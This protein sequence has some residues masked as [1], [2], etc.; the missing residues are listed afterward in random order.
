[1][2][3]YAQLGKQS[4]WY[5]TKAN[6]FLPTSKW[7]KIDDENGTSIVHKD[8]GE[9]IKLSQAAMSSAT[10]PKPILKRAAAWAGTKGEPALATA[11]MFMGGAMAAPGN[12]VAPGVAEAAGTG[13]GALAGTQ[14]ARALR[15]YG[16]VEAPTK[17]VSG[18]VKKTAKDIPGAAI[19][20]MLGPV[21]EAGIPAIGRG[22]TKLSEGIMSQVIGKTTGKGREIPEAA[23]KAGHQM[24]ESPKGAPKPA[25]TTAMRSQNIPY[26]QRQ[27][28]D[29]ARRAVRSLATKR[30]ESY[31]AAFK[32]IAGK[33]NILIDRNPVM[34]VA[35]DEYGKMFHTS[36][37]TGKQFTGLNEEDQ[38]I[39]N[40]ARDL[41]ETWDE[42]NP[43]GVD[44]LKR[45]LDNIYSPNK[46][47]RAYVSAIKDQVKKSLS[48]VPGYSDMTASY[49]KA[50]SLLDEIDKTLATGDKKAPAQVISRLA[51][52]M[53]DDGIRRELVEALSEETG[54][55][56]IGKLAGLQASQVLPSGVGPVGFIGSGLAAAHYVN[57]KLYPI[58]MAAS[59][60]ASSEFLQLYGR[61]LGEIAAG[62]RGI[63]PEVGPAAKAYA[64]N[65]MSKKRRQWGSEEEES[66]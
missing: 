6:Q 8:T 38:R 19:A 32:D 1:M 62:Y 21:A 55:D 51:S 31:R 61:G 43:V 9:K 66:E 16:G 5:D 58:L 47:S 50:S 40:K 59:P 28:V 25:F 33:G 44:S 3:R 48:T 29:A 12:V 46:K 24:A 41:V 7:V 49:A 35:N 56:L 2:I 11:G 36:A 15:Q 10:N 26:E 53:K 65:A 17:T 60:R 13:L 27:A 42:W 57:P 30:S 39:V 45:Q 63:S 22:S 18:A 37:K 20:G 4:G 64:G 52:A 34:K 23:L 54:E 14:L